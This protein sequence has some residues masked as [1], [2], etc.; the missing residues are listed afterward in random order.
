MLKVLIVE[1]EEILR[2]GLKYALDWLALDLLLIGEAAD[3]EHG[4]RS[5]EGLRPDI[6][7]TDI[8]MP[9]LNGIEMLE[10][11]RQIYDFDCI[12]LT[13]YSDFEY[14][15]KAVKL[16]AAEYLLK[17]LDEDELITALD[18]I[19]KRRTQHQPLSAIEQ[20]LNGTN[21]LNHYVHTALNTILTEYTGRLSIELIAAREQVSHSYLSRKFRQETG[22]TFL[23]ILHEFRVQKALELLSAGRY[24]VYEVAEMTGFS[25]YKQFCAVFK[26]LTGHA[27][28]DYMN[29][30]I[31]YNPTN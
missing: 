2:N 8:K 5:I 30:R 12:L 17:P 18:K 29:K 7:I 10:K 13:S 11:A 4:L 9:R 3:G 27:P 14:A 6:V 19:R 24:R 23:D 31:E 15:R 16:E 22:R 20:L 21:R 28:T 26:K 1:D 25:D